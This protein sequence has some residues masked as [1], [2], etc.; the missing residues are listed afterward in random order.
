MV[1][2]WEMCASLTRAGRSLSDHPVQMCGGES[3]GAGQ[4]AHHGRTGAALDLPT[5]TPGFLSKT[6]WPATQGF[7]W[8]VGEEVVAEDPTICTAL[9]HNLF[10]L[11]LSVSACATLGSVSSLHSL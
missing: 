11:G 6:C 2:S 4:L 5:L 8:K 1:S 9:P 3:Q 7:R 10:S